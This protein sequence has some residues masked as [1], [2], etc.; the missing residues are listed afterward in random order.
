MFQHICGFLKAMTYAQLYVFPEKIRE[1]L[2]LPPLTELESSAQASS[3][4]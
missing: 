1:V 4:T 2:N 3:K